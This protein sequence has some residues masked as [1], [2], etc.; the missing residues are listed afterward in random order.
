MSNIAIIETAHTRGSLV[1]HLSAKPLIMV[2][3]SPVDPYIDMNNPT[4]AVKPKGLGCGM[5]LEGYSRV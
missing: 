2:P 4:V 3:S 1:D 5:E